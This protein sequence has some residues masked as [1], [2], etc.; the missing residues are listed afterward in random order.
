M[1]T[2]LLY[3]ALG[4]L[5]V[6]AALTTWRVVTAPTPPDRLLAG[7][8]TIALLTFILAV[9]AGLG[10]SAF[11]LDAALTAALLA[12]VSTLVLAKFIADGTVIEP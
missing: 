6:L 8:L 3:V 12:F 11:Y 9:A 5:V 7:D 10:G 4:I 2:T 1:L